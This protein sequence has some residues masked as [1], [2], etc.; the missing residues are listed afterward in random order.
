MNPLPPT[1]HSFATLGFP[2]D[3][4]DKMLL[5]Y[6]GGGPRHPKAPSLD[7]PSH[8][9]YTE[10]A[11]E[12]A[13]STDLPSLP[14]SPPLPTTGPDATPD[15][16]MGRGVSVSELGFEAAPQGFQPRGALARKP[17]KPS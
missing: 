15:E 3:L 9:A 10:S 8:R 14:D 6:Y 5:C 4:L 11:T 2:P 12:G 16:P 17:K 1:P 13:P 7:T